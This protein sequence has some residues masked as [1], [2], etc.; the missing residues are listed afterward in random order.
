M[1]KIS[2][3]AFS[4]F[5]TVGVFGKCTFTIRKVSPLKLKSAHRDFPCS[6]YSMFDILIFGFEQR[7]ATPDA[8]TPLGG[9]LKTQSPL[10][11]SLSIFLWSSSGRFVSWSKSISIALWVASSKIVAL[12]SSLPLK[13]PQFR[14]PTLTAWVSGAIL[15]FWV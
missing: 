15:G 3:R 2:I 9:A 11:H 4:K 6:S 13:P 7:N 5:S 1:G 12:F 8:V 14:V 10:P